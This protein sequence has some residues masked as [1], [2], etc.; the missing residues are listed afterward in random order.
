MENFRSQCLREFKNLFKQTQNQNENQFLISLLGI[1]KEEFK[2]RS[3]LTIP[4]MQE[5]EFDEI[6]KATNLFIRIIDALNS[7]KDKSNKEN[8]GA[9]L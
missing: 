7:N 8:W 5:M 4:Y 9:P 2:D 1:R 6:L 3:L